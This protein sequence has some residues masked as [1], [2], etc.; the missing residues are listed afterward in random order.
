MSKATPARR[1][2]QQSRSRKRVEVILLAARE[3]IGQRGND[4]VSMREIATRAAVPIASVYDYFPDK[5]AIIRSLMID[6]LSGITARLGGILDEVNRPEH[7]APAVDRMV[8]AFVEIFR[9]ERELATI[10]SAVQANTTLRD[11]DVEDGRRIAELLIA[12]FRA[13]APAADPEG[14][15]DSCI[16]AVFTIATMTRIAIYTS[17]RDGDR[18]IAEFKRLMHLRLDSLIPPRAPTLR[19]V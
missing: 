12:K 17:P 10:W 2:P 7:L 16:Y 18:L 1:A 14:I 13:V 6:Y 11:Q 4:A 3:L 5:N 8:D 9:Q 15:A 19:P